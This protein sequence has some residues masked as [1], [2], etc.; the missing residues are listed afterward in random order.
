MSRIDF[1]VAKLGYGKADRDEVTRQHH[2]FRGS[3]VTV[4][5]C[6]NFG[7]I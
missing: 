6:Q 5:C 7:C 4:I 1:F 3:C 2:G